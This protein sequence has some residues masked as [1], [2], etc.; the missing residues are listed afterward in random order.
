MNLD[1]DADSDGDGIFDAI[2]SCPSIPNSGQE[3]FDQD[4]QGDVCDDDRDGDGV[5]NQQELTDATNPDDP[6]SYLFQ[7]ITLAR[8]DLGDC[9]SDMISN[10]IDLDDDNDG[11]LDT[12]EGFNDTDGDGIPDH[13]DKDADQDGCYDT[14][15]AGFLDE[16]DNGVLGSDP[17]V[18]D[19]QGRIIDRGIYTPTRSRWKFNL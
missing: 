13:L 12:V 8:L 11:I 18:V 1:N 5:I 17:V 19:Q 3:D 6:C 14:V 2:D 16:D 15:E 9:D 10:T 4:G 7:S